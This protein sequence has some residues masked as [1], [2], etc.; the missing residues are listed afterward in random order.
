MMNLADVLVDIH[1]ML[2][3]EAQK[4]LETDISQLT[5]V[6]EA[7][8]DSRH[9]SGCGILVEYDPEVVSAD[10]ILHRVRLH[11]PYSSMMGMRDNA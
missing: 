1:P 11:D 3:P 10:Q 5:G 8:L 6:L 4:A 7:T 2:L 9:A